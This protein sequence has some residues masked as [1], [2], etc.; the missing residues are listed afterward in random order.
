MNL[1]HRISACALISPKAS[2]FFVPGRVGATATRHTCPYSRRLQTGL[3]QAEHTAFGMLNRPAPV[4]ARPCCRGLREAGGRRSAVAASRSCQ[5]VVAA[6]DKECWLLDYGAGNVRSVRNAV[7]H[8]G[9]NLREVRRV[10]VAM[11]N[12]WKISLFYYAGIIACGHW[13]RWA[14][15]LSGGRR[16]WHR[17]RRA[18]AAWLL[19]AAKRLLA[20]MFDMLTKLSPDKTSGPFAAA[21]RRGDRSWASAW[22]CSCCSRAARSRAAWRAWASSRARCAAS[23]TAP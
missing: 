1:L 14:A 3:G 4:S 15:A 20:G 6:A 21:R 2:S 23:R 12:T 11:K 16:F 10:A 7:K 17:C 18:Q 13:A 19:G 8:L 22:A 5:R 9:Y